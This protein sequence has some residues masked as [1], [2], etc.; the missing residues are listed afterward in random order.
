[1]WPSASPPWPSL[2]WASPWST[3]DACASE[4]PAALSVESSSAEAGGR[5]QKRPE[6]D[7]AVRRAEKGVARPLGVGHQADDVAFGRTDAGDVVGGAVGV[8]DVAQDDAVVG[9]EFGQ[10]ALRARVVALEVVDGQLQH[11]TGR[12]PRR[13]HR[14]RAVDPHLDVAAQELQGPVLLQG[15]G[16]EAGLGEDLEAV[17][18]AEHGPALAG[19]RGHRAH[20][21]AE[22]GDGARAQVVAVGEA[23]G[24][25]HGVGV[26]DGV[27]AVP[28]QSGLTAGR[29]D[30]LDHVVLAVGAGEDDHANSHSIVTLAASITGLVR[31]RWHR[32]STRDRAV[33]TSGASTV[34][35]M[36]LP[37]RTPSTP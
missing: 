6:E 26:A 4:R 13:E 3:W 1:M 29:A 7:Q 36:A 2:G 20:H 11:L 25:D 14:P 22:A 23:S 18:D 37:T 34:N 31:K 17:A 28:H 8:L 27:V 24:K 10:G 30:G 16:Q 15:A 12:R 19:E 33:S 32:S 9:A 35:R 21:G 5:R